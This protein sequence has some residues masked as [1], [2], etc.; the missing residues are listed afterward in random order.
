[1]NYMFKKITALILLSACMMIFS[2][3]TFD[4]SVLETTKGSFTIPIFF[5]DAQVD[6][7]G[8]KIPKAAIRMLK[9]KS[10]GT[11]VISENIDGFDKFD[12]V[13]VKIN[14]S[15]FKH[16]FIQADDI[17]DIVFN[18]NDALV[19]YI[20]ESLQQLNVTNRKWLLTAFNK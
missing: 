2:C 20:P 16:V 15:T 6:D 8:Y 7:L 19:N 3:S 18:E 17:E 1:M 14:K 5:L 13:T 4:E 11:V 10:R 9:N 12:A